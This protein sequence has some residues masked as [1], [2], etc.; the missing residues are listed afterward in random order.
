MKP[1]LLFIAGLASIWLAGVVASAQT[2]TPVVMSPA[3]VAVSQPLREG[4]DDS[5]PDDRKVHYHQLLPH[6]TGQNRGDDALQASTG[7]ASN[8]ASGTSFPGVGASGYAPPDT[9]MA[10]GP[11]HILQTVNSRYAV[12]NK[13]GVLLVGPNSLSSLWAPLGSANGC[14]TNN[15]GDVVAQYDKLAD[16]F[17]VT[18]LGGVSAPY[19]E[20]IAISQT[21]DPTGAY[22]LYSY[23]YGT[24]LNDYPKFGVWPTA[25]NSAYLGTA[26]LCERPDV[27][28]RPALRLRPD[29]SARRGPDGTRHLLHHQQ[30]R[31]L[32]PR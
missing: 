15:G 13:G 6:G 18:Q 4:F 20:C 8:A 9:N 31:Q 21:S 12:Y 26:N 25:T 23:A 32:P 14:A 24:T 22:W 28:R 5:R 27:C 19:S 1:P 3:Q 29:S 16:R 2:M 11:N 7:S 10:V 30:R 17:I